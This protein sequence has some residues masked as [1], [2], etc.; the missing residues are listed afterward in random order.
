LELTIKCPNCKSNVPIGYPVCPYC[1]YDLRA[2]IRLKARRELTKWD[3]FTRVKK[4]L[5]TPWAIFN[6]I[7]IAPDSVGPLIIIFIFSFLSALRIM[8]LLGR[9]IP[10]SALYEVFR[11]DLLILFSIMAGLFLYFVIW[12]FVSIY[13]N[14]VIKLLG[15]RPDSSLTR[16]LTGYSAGILFI[17][18]LVSSIIVSTISSI[19]DL[20]AIAYISELSRIVLF[21]GTIIYLLLLSDGLSKAYSINRILVFFLSIP[22]PL[23]AFLV[24]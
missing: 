16:S 3:I 11:V 18:L 15:S 24:F 19:S 12:I 1:G 20:N 13:F 8:I 23:I 21:I 22:I 5:F 2:V 6:D 17:P 10:L 4:A 9:E 7:M 14:F